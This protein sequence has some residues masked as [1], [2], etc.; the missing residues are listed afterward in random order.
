[1][2]GVQL[3]RRTTESF[4]INDVGTAI[5]LY[6]IQGRSKASGIWNYCMTFTSFFPQRVMVKRG[7]FLSDWKPLAAIGEIPWLFRVAFLKVLKLLGIAYVPSSWYCNC[8]KVSPRR[9]KRID[10]T[11]LTPQLDLE[12]EIHASPWVR[13]NSSSSVGCI[14]DFLS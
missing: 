9:Y 12:H 5:E 13:A 3:S 7:F 6:T 1:M 8:L 4:H 2:R 11:T 10:C 14:Q